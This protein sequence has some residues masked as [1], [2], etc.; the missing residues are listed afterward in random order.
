M[1]LWILFVMYQLENIKEMW[2][3]VSCAQVSVDV[4]EQR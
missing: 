2:R 3:K 4:A 1:K